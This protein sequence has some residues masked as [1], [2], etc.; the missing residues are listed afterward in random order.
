MHSALS[1]AFGF[2]VAQTH[3]GLFALFQAMILVLEIADGAFE[4][5]KLLHHL[6]SLQ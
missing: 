3:E 4:L 6:F 5:A 2:F 1:S